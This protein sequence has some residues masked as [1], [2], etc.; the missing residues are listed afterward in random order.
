[1]NECNIVEINNANQPMACAIL[2][3]GLTFLCL[4]EFTSVDPIVWLVVF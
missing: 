1:M 3:A 2:I 4:F